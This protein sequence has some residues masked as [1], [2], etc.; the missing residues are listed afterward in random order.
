MTLACF[1]V[2][3]LSESLTANFFF[4]ILVQYT[5]NMAWLLHTFTLKT[6]SCIICCGIF[7]CCN[8]YVYLILRDLFCSD[9]AFESECELSVFFSCLSAF[10]Q[11]KVFFSL[12]RW[13]ESAVQNFTPCLC[14]CMHLSYKC[15]DWIRNVCEISNM[16]KGSCYKLCWLHKNIFLSKPLKGGGGCLMSPPCLESQGC[17]LIPLCYLLSCSSA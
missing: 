2:M 12:K 7:C 9:F 14:G 5:L 1:K 4:L 13:A 16:I 8:F 15:T 11:L 3:G 6:L 10:L 17:H